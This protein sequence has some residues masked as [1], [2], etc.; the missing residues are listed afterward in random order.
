MWWTSQIY[1]PSE[2]HCENIKGRNV[3]DGALGRSPFSSRVELLRGIAVTGGQ[4]GAE[5]AGS[6]TKAL[7][8]TK[9]VAG[10]CLAGYEENPGGI[11]S[12]IT[13]NYAPFKEGY[14]GDGAKVELNQ[15]LELMV[16]DLV[17]GVLRIGTT[18]SLPEGSVFALPSSAVHL[19]QKANF[20]RCLEAL[21]AGFVDSAEPENTS[22]EFRLPV[23]HLPAAAEQILRE[24]ANVVRTFK[25][26]TA[27]R[28]GLRD[29]GY[30]G[31][32][33]VLVCCRLLETLRCYV[34]LQ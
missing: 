10:A 8:Q 16:A 29:T 20:V 26:G 31:V 33:G 7:E 30:S 11:R 13:Y 3:F 19:L 28:R 17:F 9:K 24:R 5:N 18:G 21:E 23:G 15:A 12:E 4:L 6:L 1:N 14:Y 32:V 34:R 27:L 2:K 22:I 25:V